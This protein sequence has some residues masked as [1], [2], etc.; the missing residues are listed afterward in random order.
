MTITYRNG[1]S[2]GE[3]VVYVPALCIAIFLAIKH[4]F[5]RSSGWYFL[6]VFSLARIIGAGMQLATI[7]DPRNVSLYIGSAILTNVGFSPLE[8]A[9]LGLLSRLIE[10]INKTH[11]TIVS[12]GVMKVIEL[13]IL[14]GLILGIVGGI[15]AGN[16]YTSTGT[17]VPNSLNKAGTAL[18]I[19]SYVLTVIATIAVSLSASH[20]EPGEHRLLFAIAFALPLLLVRL[21]YSIFSTFAHNKNFNLITG[22][23]TILLCVA[24]LEELA[25][26]ICYEAV[27]LTLKKLPKKSHG[28]QQVGSVDSSDA[29]APMMQ[30]KK[31]NLA[32]KIAKKTI[33][34]R[35][36][37]AFVPSD[38]H[39]VRDVEMQSQGFE[40]RR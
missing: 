32:L 14:V 35:I 17:Y 29:S 6:V 5:G 9:T 15:N 4:G 25:V 26:T 24:L 8:L 10:S 27:G 40:Q 22:N 16:A 19:V 37:M 11:K 18:L 7:N 39:K 3:I 20:A 1:V 21:V 23:T 13:I 38:D 28:V 2:I 33:I 34:G 30:E 36:V 12:S 31:E